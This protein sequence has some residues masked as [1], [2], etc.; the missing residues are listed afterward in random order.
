MEKVMSRGLD[1]EENDT[2]EARVAG[3]LGDGSDDAAM[4]EAQVA[5][6]LL[7]I[8]RDLA[9]GLLS[10]A[11]LIECLDLLLESAMRLPDFD[12]GGIY[13]CDESTGGL[14]L[15]AHR[16]LTEAFV[17]GAGSYPADSPQAGLV[18]SGKLA[19]AM[20]SDFPPEIGNAIAAEGLEALAIL[21]MRDRGQVIASLN[22]SSHRYLRIEV[23]SRVALESLVAQ[24]EGAITSI[25]ER[26]ARGLAE[27][28]L[29]LA[30]EGAELGSWVA[31]FETGAF[32]ASVR[33]REQHGLAADEP[34]TL[35]SALS[36]IHPDDKE[37]IGTMLRQSLV[38]DVPYSGEYRIM[39][40]RGGVRW[41]GSDARFFDGNGG[42]LLYGISR[43][44]TPGKKA[45]AALIEARDLLEA[46]VAERTAELEAANVTLREKSKGLE[47]ALDASRAGIWSWDVR[48]GAVECDNRERALYGFEDD[49]ALAFPDF[50]ERIHPDDRSRL[51]NRL[52][53]A[54]APGGS[55]F[56]SI[57]FSILH[58]V[59]GERWLGGL[60]SIERDAGGKA[61]RIVGINFDI[62]ER[63][64]FERALSQS[65][66]KYRTLYDSMAD[67]FV[68]VDMEG[69][70]VEHN[71]AFQE[72][73]G[74]S[75]EEL[76][77][78]TYSDITPGKWHAL[79]NRIVE[80][81]IIPLGYSDTYEKEYRRKDGTVFPVELRTY[82]IR[83]AKGNPASMW[84]IIR[85]ITERKNAERALRDSSEL[86]SEFMRCSPIYN[87]IKI[88]TKDESRVLLASE[89]YRE[90]IGIPGSFMVG[91][92]MQELFPAEI[93]AEI[94]A[95]DWSVV[96][97]GAMLTVDEQ[98]NGR[99]Y[100]TIKFPIVQ[101]DRTLLAGYTMDVTDRVLMEKSLKEWNQ[102]LERRVVERTVELNQSEARFRQ[103]AEATFEGI[104]VTENAIL[105]DGNPQL[106]EIHGYELAEM[107][108]RPVMDF[109]APESR[110]LVTQ[111]LREGY[112]A[113]YECYG[114][115]K[116]GSTFPAEVHACM[117][118]WHGKQTR[119]TAL[120][121]LTGVKQAA[122][123]LQAQQTELEHAQRL[124]LVSE[125]S[126]GIIHQIGQPL[127]G[128]GANLAAALANVGSC[129]RQSCGAF[130]IIN[131][132]NAD[133]ERLRKVV[134]HLR[135]LANPGRANR[136]RFD[137]NMMVSDVLRLLTAEAG[138]RSMK[139]ATKLGPD[140]PE[141]DGDSVQLSQIVLN[142]V[143]NA[144]D[145]CAERPPDE[146]RVG[147]VTRLIE[148]GSLLELCVSDS[149]TGIAPDALENLFA[150]FFTTK[151]EGLGMGLRLSQTIVHAHGGTIDGR[152]NPDGVGATFRVSLPVDSD[153]DYPK[154]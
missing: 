51:V 43:D 48:S 32:E 108:G 4:R 147:V 137:F 106:A 65:E 6:G 94:S 126:A 148:G 38:H 62:T 109:I 2:H 39:D 90:M 15:I 130:E 44:I 77:R 12:C 104:A 33:A 87:F 60:G 144:F 7:E 45:E 86:L 64:M 79:E 75:I 96:S 5:M 100:T 50:I 107:I 151:P 132:V 149:G 95:D 20:R 99:H 49:V 123:S 68:R 82:L 73:L 23:S 17:S 47:L 52:Q 98:L 71:R 121:D 1:G 53:D 114:L 78:L 143:R 18:R 125:V 66:E 127:C 8:Q 154:V 88:V 70:I 101:G 84:A 22:V 46:R 113:A 9:I 134:V 61:R 111:H 27:R 31:D 139:I 37:R 97:R 42:R 24:A 28:R 152:N 140:L 56:W 141:M 135:A 120:R 40:A 21:P 81:Q 72:M 63:K 34:L 131:D 128:M 83:D 89:N 105:V 69:R 10:C 138:R 124:G 92:T 76:G 57:E 67:A 74:Y 112:G 145:S 142:L 16:G 103:L 118:S 93:A 36:R 80:E 41:I 122:A 91:K 119:V 133:V 55:D 35:E 30:V 153:N 136:A 3:V 59:H 85:D 11:D 14:R 129:D 19:Y 25:R 58:P 54:T 146:R 29:R 102:T 117:R 150:P 116:N 13:L 26:E 115:R 110:A